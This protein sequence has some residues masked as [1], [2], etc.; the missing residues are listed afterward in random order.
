MGQGMIE[1]LLLLTLTV[2]LVVAVGKGVGVPMGKYIDDNVLGVVRCMLRV[3]QFPTKSFG[4]CQGAVQAQLDVTGN[5]STGSGGSNSASSA[6]SSTSSSDSNNGDNSQNNG[7][8]DGSSTDSDDNTKIRSSNSTGAINDSGDQSELGLGT[9]TRIKIKN[10]DAGADSKISTGKVGAGFGETTVIVRRIKRKNERVSSRFTISEDG[11]SAY[12]GVG[13]ETYQANR[14]QKAPVSEFDRQGKSN[15]FGI[16]KTKESDLR[17]PA[18]DA[19]VSFSFLG[20]IKWII[21][22]AVLFFIVVFAA[23]QLN[24]IRKGWTD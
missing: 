3:G 15:R 9:T 17:G 24:S 10:D 13:P 7:S 8:D 11:N 6:N 21:I 2:A 12:E 18:S 16:P 20:M 1:Y 23:S 22:I 5:F 19:E 14:S 4:L